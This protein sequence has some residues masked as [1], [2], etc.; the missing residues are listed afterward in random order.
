MTVT[1]PG[2]GDV[3]PARPLAAQAHA[4]HA[5]AVFIEHAGIPGLSLTVDDGEISIQV[6]VHLA[7]PAS[8]AAAVA[9]LAA[10]AG[11]RAARDDRPGRTLGWIRA[12]GQIAG[13]HVRIFTAIT[14]ETR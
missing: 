6:P 13:H 9:L 14:E 2:A 11:G 5:A 8:R 1:A 10:A 12:D 7:G 4:L 3:L